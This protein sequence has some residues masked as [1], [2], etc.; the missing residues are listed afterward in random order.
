[1]I[2]KTIQK[3]LKPNLKTIYETRYYLVRQLSTAPNLGPDRVAPADKGKSCVSLYPL[4]HAQ[5]HCTVL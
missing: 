2:V 3:I 5:S 4:E 1:M